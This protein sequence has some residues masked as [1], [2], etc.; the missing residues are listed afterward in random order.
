VGPHPSGWGPTLFAKFNQILGLDFDPW[1][2][3]D[4][5]KVPPS[6]SSQSAR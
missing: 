2:R 3:L 5:I 4:W 1:G 6:L